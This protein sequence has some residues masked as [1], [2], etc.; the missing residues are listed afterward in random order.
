MSD[1]VLIDILSR[2][3]V[4]FRSLDTNQNGFLEPD[5][6]QRH[7][8]ESY[9]THFMNFCDGKTSARNRDNQIDREEFEEY[10][11]HTYFHKGKKEALGVLEDLES[12]IEHGK[13]S[14]DIESVKNHASLMFDYI[15]QDQ[16]GE[17]EKSE[18]NYFFGHKHASHF[19]EQVDGAVGDGNNA[20]SRDEW[21]TYFSAIASE[22]GK[23]AAEG[24]LEQVRYFVKQRRM[25][26][27]AKTKEDLEV[28]EYAAKLFHNMDNDDDNE[29]TMEELVA[30]VGKENA[31]HFVTHMDHWGDGDGSVSISEWT[32]YF[33]VICL[34][35]SHSE[36]MESLKTVQ[37]FQEHKNTLTSVPRGH[38]ASDKELT[39][40]ADKIFYIINEDKSGFIDVDTAASYFGDSAASFVDHV[41]FWGANK[42]ICTLDDWRGFFRDVRSTLSHGRAVQLLEFVE[43]TIQTKKQEEIEEKEAKKQ[44][45]KTKK[46]KRR[47]KSRKRNN[48][49]GGGLGASF[50][51]GGNASVY[52]P[53]L[54]DS[55]DS[56]AEPHQRGGGG[57]G[58]GGSL[59]DI[60][61]DEKNKI[62]DEY[63]EHKE[64]WVEQSIKR[65]LEHDEL[66]EEY[67][68]TRA[69]LSSK[70]DEARSEHHDAS[71]NL[72]ETRQLL[73]KNKMNYEATIE[74]EM[75]QEQ[76]FS[77]RRAERLESEMERA[78]ERSRYEIRNLKR[79]EEDARARAERLSELLETNRGVTNRLEEKVSSME[80]A[81]SSQMD[82][83]S[84]SS[85]ENYE[86]RMLRLELSLEKQK[87]LLREQDHATSLIRAELEQSQAEANEAMS[88]LRSEHNSEISEA[89]SRWKST[90]LRLKHDKA[91][92]GQ[93]TE[94]ISQLEVTQHQVNTLAS[95]NFEASEK[96]RRT[97][98][99]LLE[100]RQHH[101]VEDENIEMTE[102]SS[103]EMFRLELK[104]MKEANN[105]QRE[106][107][108][109]KL[110]ALL[111]EAKSTHREE[112]EKLRSEQQQSSSVV[113]VKE[114]VSVPSENLINAKQVEVLE[115]RLRKEIMLRASTEAKQQDEVRMLRDAQER[116]KHQE[117]TEEM[118]SQVRM[119]FLLLCFFFVSFRARTLPLT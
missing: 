2:A 102:R 50:V 27:N 95:L 20:I 46:E 62:K 103:E 92:K 87:S 110:R 106:S 81:H 74:R 13:F 99:E 79:Y 23:E 73:E 119:L 75:K 116:K 44:R 67:E 17:I 117:E 118:L 105:R 18:L 33:R 71:K 115:E 8:G 101:H 100:A 28:I 89:R 34:T 88:K 84:K 83:I 70:L 60:M 3:D 53:G 30:V 80:T 86:N 48:G 90:L 59:L 19:L 43:S 114:E 91:K 56:D 16:S 22:S 66:E 42:G 9:V 68:S 6:I 64:M 51:D 32:R 109:A 10:F 82:L 54:D 37:S 104:E 85:Q 93:D 57:G 49:G 12:W 76:S 36:A 52:I 97:E 65:A 15:D 40:R 5:E 4:V 26:D 113:V 111:D 78:S 38:T 1:K 11:Q 98:A 31:D 96:L 61:E 35:Q 7:L 45:R 47:K 107:H 25:L 94:L 63:E 29:L 72:K 41:S 39:E 108:E 69:E 112:L 58:G 14:K 21:E 55:D 77:N 24:E